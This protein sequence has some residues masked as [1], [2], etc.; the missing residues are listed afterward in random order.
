LSRLSSLESTSKAYGQAIRWGEYQV[1]SSFVRTQGTDGESP[2]LKKLEKI[3]VISY[4]PTERNTSED[5]LQAHQAVEIKYYNTDYLIEKTLIDK[6]LWEYDT[7]QKAWY[8][9]SALPDFK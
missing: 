9:Q 6:Q 3:K 8:L 4:K 5:K 1:A 7:K 2:N